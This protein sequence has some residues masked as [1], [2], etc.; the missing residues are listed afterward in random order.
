M[1]FIALPLQS[2][3]VVDVVR[4]KAPPTLLLG[5][6][7][8]FLKSLRQY[9]FRYGNFVMICDF[10]GDAIFSGEICDEAWNV[11]YRN[12]MWNHKQADAILAA[13]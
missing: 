6:R 8:H 7:L 11:S 13:K 9:Q 5:K 3:V 2:S 4:R 10:Y 1:A 12:S